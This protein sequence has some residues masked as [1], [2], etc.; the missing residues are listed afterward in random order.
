M[1]CSRYNTIDKGYEIVHHLKST[2]VV[3]LGPHNMVEH[4]ALG[5]PTEMAEFYEIFQMNDEGPL[6]MLLLTTMPI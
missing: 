3:L 2:A 1:S 4:H 5:V 6:L